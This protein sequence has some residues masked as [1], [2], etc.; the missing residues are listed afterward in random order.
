MTWE[1]GFHLDFDPEF[2]DLSKEVQNE[3]LARVKLLEEFGPVLARPWADTL[4]GSN[5][6]NMK[7]LRFNVGKGLWRVAFAFDPVRKGVIL[8]ADDKRGINE[9]LF[10][11]RL[12]RKADKR[13]DVYLERL[14]SERRSK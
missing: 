12:I 13:F 3:L 8:V 10:Y 2:N 5:H 7:E 6:A 14:K 1:V 4:K 9:K 11:R